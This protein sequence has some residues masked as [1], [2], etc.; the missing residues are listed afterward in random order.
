MSHN[1]KS[2]KHMIRVDE[3]SESDLQALFDIVLKPDAKKPLNLPWSMR[4]MPESFFKPPLLGSKSINNIGENSVD[5]EIGDS[6]S[7]TTTST[8]PLPSVHHRAHS[9]PASLQETY[10][11]DLQ[12]NTSCHTKSNYKR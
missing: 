11:V 10:A 6:S 8:V 1:Q 7:A 9:S 12:H 2:S 4:K 5:S 3:E